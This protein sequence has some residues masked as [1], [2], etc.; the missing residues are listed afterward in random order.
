MLKHF[1]IFNPSLTKLLALI[2]LMGCLTLIASCSKELSCEGCMDDNKPPIADA[3]TDQLVT[4]PAD[5]IVLDGRASKDPDGTITEWRWR[6]ISGPALFTIINPESAKPILKQFEAGIYQFEL[7][8][9]DNGGLTG[10]DTVEITVQNAAAVDYPPVANAGPDLSIILPVN[11]VIIDGSASTDPDNNIASYLWKKIS[12]PATAGVIVQKDSAITAVT[13]LAAGHYQ[14][15]LTVTDATGLSDRDTVRIDVTTQTGQAGLIEVIFYWREPTGTVSF[16]SDY[17]PFEWMEWDSGGS[18][19]KLVTVNMDTLTDYLAGV[20]CRTCA[21]NCNSPYY[22]SIFSDKNIV[23]FQVPP[24][25]YQWKAE[26]G[27][28]PFTGPNVFL[29]ITPELYNFFNTTHKTSGTVTVSPG[30]K[31]VVVEIIF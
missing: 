26:T 12:G 31:C 9:K 11:A 21:A 15:E 25:V 2:T 19:L 14:F 7:S 16:V 10:K 18:Y 1:H 29:S 24:G 30:D 13:G 4:L 27:T 20:W 3:G 23:T 5:S 6:K 17:G 22:A 28:Q 8:V